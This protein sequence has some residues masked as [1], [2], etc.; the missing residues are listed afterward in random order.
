MIDYTKVVI[1]T[2]EISSQFL[3]YYV[4]HLCGLT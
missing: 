4:K 3:S 2:I 1:E